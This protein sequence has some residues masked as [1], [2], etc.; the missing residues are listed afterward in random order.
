MKTRLLKCFAGFLFVALMFAACK[1]PNSIDGIKPADYTFTISSLPYA[2][3]GL[4]VV[5]RV[6]LH[7]KNYDYEL[8]TIGDS[9]AD[10]V[11]EKTVK[12]PVLYSKIT[13]FFLDQD[14]KEIFYY[15]VEEKYNKTGSRN[16][17]IDGYYYYYYEYGY[18]SYDKPYYA[19]SEK[20]LNTVEF[21]KTYEFDSKEAPF[22]MFKVSGVLN[23][24]I[25]IKLNQSYPRKVEV[26][27]ANSK[28]K[29]M[30]YQ[31]ES[32]N[33]ESEYDCSGN[34]AYFM[35]R[36]EKYTD[37][38]SAKITFTNIS[39]AIEN[40]LYIQQ[41]KNI[42]PVILASDGKLYATGTNSASQAKDILY[43][44]DP[45]TLI[46]SVAATVPYDID[47]VEELDTG[48]LYIS[49]FD[50]SSKNGVGGI[51]TLNLATKQ[52]NT[53][54][55]DLNGMAETMVN[56]KNGKFVVT[57]FDNK[58]TGNT[59]CIYL[60]DKANG[61]KTILAENS[62]DTIAVST[63]LFYFASND[64]FIGT[65]NHVTSRFHYMKITE[66]GT[67]YTTGYDSDSVYCLLRIF[68]ESPLQVLCKN[69]SVFTLDTAIATPNWA[70]PEGVLCKSY[71]DCYIAGDYIYYMTNDRGAIVEK[72]AL[73]APKDVISSVKYENQV[74]KRLFCK[75]NK[76][77]LLANSQ[78]SVYGSNSTGDYMVYIHEIK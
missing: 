22:M 44:L 15:P 47:C 67:G 33:G 39:F 34:E 18:P 55:N 68:K 38:G 70:I 45:D 14:K 74:G 40:G 5:A 17:T 25:G 46:R 10:T 3:K 48:T 66:N 4:T 72:C 53:L 9:P 32:L 76:V 69:G 49:Y 50:R 2:S 42:D 19:L 37:E 36:T 57:G 59:G 21:G 65:T 52:M 77:Y 43:C 78:Y 31:T 54:V 13:L 11:I 23:K 24:K 71:E 64:V 63:E 28:E 16:Y 20:H 26:Y 35:V 61:T 7:N 6:N 41:N 51:I 73:S 8:G 62:T 75:D 58:S 12:M 56:Y 29:F 27:V 60:I 30:N 1:D